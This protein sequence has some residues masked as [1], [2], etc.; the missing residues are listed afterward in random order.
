MPL[1]LDRECRGQNV[2]VIENAHNSN[3]KNTLINFRTQVDCDKILS[4]GFTDPANAEAKKYGKA[5][6]RQ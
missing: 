4:V 2:T 6:G 1:F 3:L 5:I